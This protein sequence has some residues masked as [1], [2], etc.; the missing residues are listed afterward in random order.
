M[1]LTAVVNF[2]RVVSGDIT[3]AAAVVVVDRGNTGVAAAAYFVLV[4]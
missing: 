4:L 2:V 1:L 3:A